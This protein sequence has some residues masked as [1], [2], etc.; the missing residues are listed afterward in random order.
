[1]SRLFE[2]AKTG[3]RL[4]QIART[5]MALTILTAV[6]G[7]LGIVGMNDDG[8][9]ILINLLILLAIVA[10]EWFSC[11]LLHGFGVLVESSCQQKLQMEK[12]TVLLQK[13]LLGDTTG[14]A[15]PNTEPPKTVPVRPAAEPRIVMSKEQQQ[16]MIIL[17]H[18]LSLQDNEKRWKYLQEQIDGTEDE[19][20]QAICRKAIGM[21]DEQIVEL[22]DTL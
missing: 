17:G 15:M 16:T 18:L 10:A 20:V 5:M 21:T 6:I 19:Q 8:E 13:I 4:Q 11:L 14:G 3:E 9:G 1:M 2:P 7:I 12:Q 22:L